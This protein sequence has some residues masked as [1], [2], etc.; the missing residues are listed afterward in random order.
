MSVIVSERGEGKLAAIT[1]SLDLVKYTIH[2]CKNEQNFPKRDRWILT[3]DVVQEAKAQF[4][5][6]RMANSINVT[7][8]A[9]YNQRHMLQVEA[10]GHLETLLS[11]IEIAYRELNLASDRVEYW[12]G[13]VL[14]VER[15]L[16]NWANS[17]TKRF[18]HH[19]C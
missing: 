13:K 17:D 10:Y 1:E 2:I 7:T 9:E 15:L 16:K 19:G 12:T 6:M 4:R 3:N 8:D 11:W 18:T 5:C 14:S